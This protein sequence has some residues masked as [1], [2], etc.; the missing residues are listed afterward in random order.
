MKYFQNLP[1]VQ[2]TDLE[3]TSNTSTVLLTN[4][5]TRSSFLREIMDN[6]SIWYDY[7]MK[8]NETPE[9]IADKLYGDVNRHWIILMF[10]Q[11]LD[12]FYSFPLNSVQLDTYIGGKYVNPYTLHHYEQTKTMVTYLNGIIQDTNEETVIIAAQQLNFE[13]GLLEDRPDLPAVGN[14]PIEASTSTESFGSG[15]TTTTTYT[16]VAVSN[17]DYEQAE[18]EKKRA[19]KLLDKNY[20][21]VV[22]SEFRRLMRDGN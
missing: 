22:E 6:T 10:N 8:E 11:V 14:N 7:Q 12:P 17:Y 3:N 4:I 2:Y 18:N 19:I 9:I 20:V 15:I 13:T 16:N 21:T 5:L 1:M